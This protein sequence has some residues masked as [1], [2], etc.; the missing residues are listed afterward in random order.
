[1]P[2]NGADVKQICA[3]GAFILLN[4]KKTKKKQGLLPE[5]PC[6]VGLMS[7]TNNKSLPD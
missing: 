6:L 4:N 2:T 1:M 3:V 7:S 5:K